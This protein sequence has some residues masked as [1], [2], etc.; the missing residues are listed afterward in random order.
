MKEQIQKDLISAMKSKLT[1]DLNVL[2]SVKTAITNAEK[3]N[4]DIPLTNL[5]V[6]N[7]I[8]KLVKQRE[9]S[10]EQFKAAKRW[11]LVDNELSEKKILESYLPQSMSEDDLNVLVNSVIEELGATSKKD[12]GRVIKAVQEKTQGSVDNKS[13]S[14]LVGFKLN[15]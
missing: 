2:R 9:D 12:M 3:A 1:L 11:E 15:S 6:I 14:Q 5:E 13:I 4:K 10:I 7:I 8:R